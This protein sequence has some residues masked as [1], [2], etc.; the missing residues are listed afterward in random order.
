MP[1]ITNIVNKNTGD[2]HCFNKNTGDQRENR[3][4][5]A[6]T[7]AVKNARERYKGGVLSST[8][9][10]LVNYNRAQQ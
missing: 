8:P 2:Q 7:G 5:N 9:P 3:G 4:R 10:N 6:L 1:A